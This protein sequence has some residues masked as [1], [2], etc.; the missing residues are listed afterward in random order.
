MTTS[1]FAHTLSQTRGGDTPYLNVSKH[2]GTI[3]GVCVVLVV[4]VF[5]AQRFKK[6]SK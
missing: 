3:I 4:I 5:I 1:V 2:M 6:K